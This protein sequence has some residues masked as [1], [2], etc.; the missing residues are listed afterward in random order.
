MELHFNEEEAAMYV[1]I[2]MTYSDYVVEKEEVEVVS[3]YYNIEMLDELVEKVEIMGGFE[4]ADEYAIERLLSSFSV[5][6][7]TR[8]M[9][10]AYK[11][12]NCDGE[13][14][15]EERRLMSKLL[16]R[17]GLDISDVITY[18]KSRL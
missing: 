13:Y 14:H 1:A 8:V 17:L 5:D 16:E 10:I 3:E 9:A 4:K 6:D 18:Y 7:L 11:I 12:A 15:E 2:R